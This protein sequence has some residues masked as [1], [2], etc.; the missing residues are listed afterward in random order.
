VCKIGNL[1]F[2]VTPR[3]MGPKLKLLGKANSAFTK[4]F[5]GKT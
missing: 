3:W 4:F 2:I 1:V 5:M